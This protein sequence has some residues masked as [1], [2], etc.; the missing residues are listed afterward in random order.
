MG[1]VRKLWEADKAKWEEVF[2]ESGE[3][4]VQTGKT[5]HRKWRSGNRLGGLMDANHAF[6]QK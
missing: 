3:D 2:D 1:D 5:S 6:L 4:V